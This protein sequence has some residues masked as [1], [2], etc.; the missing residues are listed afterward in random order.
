M[1]KVVALE[2]SFDTSAAEGSVKS[3]KAQMREAQAEVSKMAD[4][5][6][7]TSVQAANAAKKAAELKDRIGDAKALTEAFNP[8]AKFKALSGALSVVAGGFAAVQGAMGLMGAES[9]DVEK[10]MLK[11]QSAMALATGLNA[12][13]EAADAWK[14]LKAVAMSYT[15]VQKIVTAAQWVWNAAMAAN[16]IGAIVAAVALL[17][18]GIVALT[19]YFMSNAAAAKANAKAVDESAKALE[20][21]SKQLE[22]NNQEYQKS[23]DYKLA[24]LKA[25]GASA[26][27]IREEE[28]NQ[29]ALK[30]AYQISNRALAENT[31]EKNKNLLATLKA[32]DADDD[33]IKKQQETTNKS[34]E[35]FN[36]QNQNVQAA[37]DERVALHRKQNLEIATEET[38]ANKKSA[39]DI[40][41]ANEKAK[42][43]RDAANEKAKADREAANKERLEAD[44]QL[45]E[46]RRTLAQE[47]ELKNIKDENERAK[48]KLDFD[49]LNAKKSIE[50]SKASDVEKFQSL[51]LL[52]TNWIT[53]KNAIDAAQKV[54]KDKEAEDALIKEGEDIDAF[55]LLTANKEL[56]KANNQKL[57]FDERLAAVKEHQD[58]ED[59]IIFESD[60]ARLAYEQANAEARKN[61]QKE[62]TAAVM[63]AANETAKTLDGVAELIGKHTMAGKIMAIASSVITTT[64]SAIT[65]YQRGLEIPY[66]G[67]VLGPIN[68][69]IA[70]AA[71]LANIKK[72]MAVQIP[73]KGGGGGG[74]ASLP[75]ASS[76]PNAPVQPQVQST[77]L[78]Q[79]Q[80]NQ[81]SS[82]TSRAFVLES[83][84]SG[85]QERIQR[86]NRAARIN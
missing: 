75:S 70:I 17:I 79:G 12:L 18:A 82:A 30:I 57:S 19:S 47:E 6:G 52:Y 21:E 86:L 43:D 48:R 29:A 41:A 83:D 78:N 2:A 77:L 63:E 65:A 15:I 81:L 1:A 69:G 54:K 13:G 38:N 68:A 71:G 36:K 3:L 50:N 61:I 33:A 53:D 22:R 26:K 51:Q 56:E 8:D 85:N 14:R 34:V 28:L 4:K 5:F 37:L 64:T 44:K 49:Y 73:G 76:I 16:P 27:A 32:N 84:V 62:Q 9:K 31:L 35:E 7:E 59:T 20:R 10:T 24:M 74:G 39:D 72:I 45:Q 23:S 40:K 60:A 46:Q 66:V 67:M 11:V 80:V 55:I 25:S 58:L 42:A